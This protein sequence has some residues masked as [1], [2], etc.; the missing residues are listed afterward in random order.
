MATN[1]KRLLIDQNLPTDRRVVHTRPD[2]VVRLIREKKFYI[3]EVSCA[4]E[5]LV[6]AREKEKWS[7]YQELAADLAQQWK[8]FRVLV[9]PIDVG[10]LG[11]VVGMRKQLERTELFSDTES[12]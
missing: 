7:K 11:L 2:L 10:D 5:P 4:W 9:V 6:Q 3:F 1:P 8:G 12:E